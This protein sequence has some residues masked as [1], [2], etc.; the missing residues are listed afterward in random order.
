M[1]GEK[2]TLAWREGPWVGEDAEFVG[3]GVSFVLGE[4]IESMV[5]PLAETSRMEW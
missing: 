4:G 2:A 5:N 1:S 3:V